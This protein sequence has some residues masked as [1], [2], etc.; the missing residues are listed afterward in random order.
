MEKY[1][2]LPIAMG[3]ENP[4]LT[5]RNQFI[6]LPDK[7]NPK[8]IDD[9]LT[10][11]KGLGDNSYHFRF[12]CCKPSDTTYINVNRITKSDGLVMVFDANDKPS[13]LGEVY[14]EDP[15]TVELAFAVTDN[16]HHEGIGKKLLGITA[17][18]AANEINRRQNEKLGHSVPN[19][20]GAKGKLCVLPDNSPMNNLAKSL[21]PD[22]CKFDGEYNVYTIDLEKTV[23]SIFPEAFTPNEVTLI[24]DHS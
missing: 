7:S 6:L 20:V 12:N 24:G 3:R 19:R 13:G 14:I 9:I 21:K 1:A 22:G 5:V 16:H 2:I 15:N 4:N 17:A 11:F 8:V 10:I 18:V 23:R